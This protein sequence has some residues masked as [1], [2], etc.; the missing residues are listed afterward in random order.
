[1]AE[2]VIEKDRKLSDVCGSRN[3]CDKVYGIQK[4]TGPR[5]CEGKASVQ[6][7]RRQMKSGKGWKRKGRRMA[8]ACRSDAGQ[9]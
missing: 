5:V 4:I 9:G 2:K 7:T 6:R 1:M 3:A 8:R